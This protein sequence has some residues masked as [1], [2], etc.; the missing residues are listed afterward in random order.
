MPD[1]T[2]RID[3]DALA[4]MAHAVAGMREAFI[5]MGEALAR[6]GAQL[7]AALPGL[8][9]HYERPVERARRLRLE[10]WMRARARRAARRGRR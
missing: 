8:R 6:A 2:P 10:R 9:R 7:A 5:R 1:L 4:R 3:P